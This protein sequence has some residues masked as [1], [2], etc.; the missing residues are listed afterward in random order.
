MGRLYGK[1]TVICSDAKERMAHFTVKDARHL[2]IAPARVKVR[3]KTVSGS[4]F[5]GAFYPDRSSANG[6]ILPLWE[7][8]Q[9]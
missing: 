7:D 3:G 9:L 8:E 5:Q 1:T 4:V 6:M 2:E